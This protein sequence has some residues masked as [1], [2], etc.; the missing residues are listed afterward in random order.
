MGAIKKLCTRCN[1]I[2]WHEQPSIFI[3]ATCLL[4]PV[5]AHEEAELGFEGIKP[6]PDI[7]AKAEVHGENIW[8]GY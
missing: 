2:T 5:R 6:D 4:C 3:D 1:Q 7:Q 8:K